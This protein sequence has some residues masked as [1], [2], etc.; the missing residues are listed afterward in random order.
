MPLKGA[1]PSSQRQPRPFRWGITAGIVVAAAIALTRALLHRQ[2]TTTGAIVEVRPW[3]DPLPG[4]G[5]PASHPVKVKLS[6]GIYHVPSGFNYPRTKPD[7]CYVS[8][9]AA[10]ADGFRAS[11]R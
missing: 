8:A 5:A 11:K 7:R 2:A 3:V 1:R 9:A 6:S 4:G 10:E